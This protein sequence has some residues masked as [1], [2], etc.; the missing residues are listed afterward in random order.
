M[1]IL[2]KKATLIDPKNAFHYSIKDILITNGIITAIEDDIVDWIWLELRD[3][4]DDTNILFSTSAL[5]QRDGDIVSA[6]EQAYLEINIQKDNYYIVITH[7]NHLGVLSSS[8][9]LCGCGEENNLDF[10]IDSNIV[11][12]GTNAI[13]DMGNG[14]FAL[15]A[16]DFNGDG[17][18][19]NTDKNAVEPLRGISGYNNAD[20]DMNGEVQNTDLNSTL[21]PNIGKG[22][23][24]LGKQLNAKRKNNN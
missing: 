15:Y 2:L 5:L 22:Q 24:Y 1:K 16:G 14:K 8:S 9:I 12:G 21:N 20:V 19:Q 7:R 3:S 17:Q 11:K 23:Q 4:K 18:I 10:K 6:D 13:K